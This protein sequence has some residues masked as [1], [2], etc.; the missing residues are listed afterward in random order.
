MD[1]SAN[2]GVRRRDLRRL[3]DEPFNAWQFQPY[4]IEFSASVAALGAGERQRVLLRGAA[5]NLIAG[6]LLDRQDNRGHGGASPDG[7]DHDNGRT[8]F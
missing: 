8:D 7:E 1:I 5:T 6:M 3:R 4:V 2:R